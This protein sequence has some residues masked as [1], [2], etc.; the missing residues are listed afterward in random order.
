MCVV[1]ILALVAMLL[2]V[3]ALVPTLAG[4]PVLAVAVLLL[5][6]CALLA[7]SSRPNV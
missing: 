4:Y 5:G 1:T 7:G 3:C 2:A 6:I